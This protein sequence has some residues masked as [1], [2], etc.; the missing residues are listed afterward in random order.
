MPNKREIRFVPVTNGDFPLLRRWLD[1]PHIREWWGGTETE[2][3][4]IRDKVEGRDAT[5]PF[6]FLLDGVPTGYIQSW[7]V[8]DAVEGGDAE[9]APWLLD[10]PSDAIGVDLFV[11]RPELLGK[12][13]GTA[14]LRA[15]LAK[16]FAEGVRTIVIDPDETNGRAVR[17]YEKAG[18]IAYDRFRNDNGVTLLMRITPERFAEM[19]A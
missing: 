10:L 18:F 11:G 17:A 14:V 5:R 4:K 1:S 3:A 19:T 12:G 16:L 9:E 8:G 7:F 13:I 15:F 2:L 6:I